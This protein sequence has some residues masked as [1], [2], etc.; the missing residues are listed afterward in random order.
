MTQLKSLID[1]NQIHRELEELFFLHQAAILGSDY[2][3][4]KALF[5]DFEDGLLAHMREEEE[6]LLPLYRQ[7]AKPVRGGDSDFFTQEHGKIVEW[8]GRL[9]L[10]LSRL[11]PPKPKTVDVLALLDD[12]AQFKKYMEHHTLREDR[13]LYPE[14]D[15]IVEEKEKA[16]LLR[17]L[18]FTLEENTPTA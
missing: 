6:I 7:R 8:L 5:Q 16:H 9:T 14:V 10:R 3:A 4:A 17:L 1:L 18:T 13:I 2:P 15:R 12:E 11:N